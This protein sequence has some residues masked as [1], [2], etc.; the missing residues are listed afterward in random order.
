MTRRE[1]GEAALR[2]AAKRDPANAAT[3]YNLGRILLMHRHHGEAEAQLRAAVTL[4][5]DH[6]NAWHDLGHVLRE[7]GRPK[8]ALDAYHNATIHLPDSAQAHSDYGTMLFGF[9]RHQEAYDELRR[10]LT[11]DPSSASAHGN[12]GALLLRTGYAI[13]AE[14]EC[15]TA[16]AQSPAQYRWLTNL[17]V[18]LRMQCR[19]AEAAECARKALAQ[20]A[21]YA[22]AHGNLLFDLT[23][24]P[25]VSAAAIFAEFRNWD[26]CHARPLTP[27]K[28]R[29]AVDP[30]PGRKLR[31]GY[32]S[33]D[34]RQHAVALFAEPLLR[35]HDRAFLELYLYSGV[36]AEDD[37]TRRFHDLADAWRNTVTLNDGQL[38]EVIRNDRIDV[39][40]DLS[41]HS[42]CNRLLTFARRPAP[43]QVSYLLG[44]GY[45]TGLSEMDAFLADDALAPPGSE[46]FFSEQIIRLPRIPLVYAPPLDMPAVEPL[47][48]LTR[49]QVAFGYFGRTERLNDDVVIAWARILAAVPHARLVLNNLPFHEPA[50]RAQF[51]A[52][53][54]KQGISSDRLDFVYTEPQQR[55]WAAYGEIDIALDPFPHNA[56]TTTIEA[57]WQGVP[58]VSLAGQPS[59]GRF[60]AS[61]LHAVGLDDWVTS[62]TD[63]Y[64]ARAVAA[65]SDLPALA[66]LRERLRP[67]MERSPLRDAAS[68]AR[69]VEQAYR[70]LWDEWRLG[71]SRRLHQLYQTGD[72]AGAVKVAHRILDR[73]PHNG[74]AHHVL[75]LLAYQDKRLADA[76]R[77][78]QAAISCTPH[79]ADLHANRAAILRKLGCLAEAEAAARTA[80]KLEP[81][82]VGALNNL[83]NILRDAGRYD[84]GAEQFRA[85]VR[86]APDFADAWVNLAWLLSLAGRAQ[87]A[88]DAARHAIACAPDNADAY[89]NLGLALMRQGRL[90][91]AEAA[92]RQALALRPDFALPHSNILFCLNYRPDAT[93]EE[94]FAEYQEWDRRHALPLWPKDACHDLDR[95]PNRK[96]RVGYVS[97]DFRQH[98]VALFA[99]PLLA[100][101]DRS[102]VEVHCYSEVAAP[103][104]VTERFRAVADHWHNTVGLSDADLAE[105]I[106]ADHID[107]L[108]DMAGHT[109]GNRLLTFAR[110]PAPIQVTYLLGHGY[111]SGLSAM[112][113][114][115]ADAQLAPPDADHLFSEQVIRLSRIPLCYQPPVEMPDVGP[116]PARSSGQ[117]TFGYFGRTVRLNDDVITAWARI[118]KHVPNARLVLN[119][120][121]FGEPAGREQMAARFAAL[122]IRADRLTLTCTSP[123]PVTWAAYGSVDIA[124]DPFPHNAGTTTIEALWQGVPVVSLAGRPTVGRFG[125][126]IL[127]AVGLDDWVTRDVDAYVARA[128]AAAADVDALAHLRATLRQ[129]FAASPLCD[130]AGLAREFESAYRILWQAWCG[131][132]DTAHLRRLYEAGDTGKAGRLAEALLARNPDH[133]GALHILGLIQLRAGDA[134]SAA[135]LL[136]HAAD[137]HP[138]AAI[139]SDLGV[140][141]RAQQRFTEAEATC[142]EALHLDPASASGLGNLGNILL[143]LHRPHEAEAELARALDV[144]PNRPWLLH[145]LAL[146][147]LAQGRVDC[148]E[149]ALRQALAVDPTAADA[150]ETLANLLSQSGRPVESEAHHRAALTEPAQRHR[151]L[152]NLAVALQVQGKH[153]EAI[154]AC[155]QALTVR[156]DYATAHAN[157]LFALN[158]AADVSAHDVFAE[159]R[160]WDR[161]H[162]APV[163]PARSEFLLDRTA[164]RRLRI[165]YVSADF[166]NHAAAFF[167][168]PLLAAHDRSN[169][170]L[171]CYAEVAAADAV[172][173]RFHARADQWRNISGMSDAAVAELIRQDQ[174]DV[175]VDMTGHTAG[176]RLLV[177]A[178]KPAPVQ[179]AYLLGHGYSSGLSA[180]D[181]F[182]SD[183]VLTPPHS[184]PYFSERIVRLPRLP[185][186][187]A[188]P[189]EMPPVSQLP[190]LT[191]RWVAFGYFG[192]PDRLTEDVVATW[193]RILDAVPRSRL[194]LN[195]FSFREPAFRGFM[196]MRFAEHGI[197]RRRL[198]MLATAPQPRT[199]AAYGAIDIALDPFPHNAGTTTIEALWQGVPVISL[200]G[201]PSVGRFGA[202]ILH[203]VAMDDWVV[204]DMNDY[205]ARAAAA[206]CDPSRLALTRA[207]LR[208]RVA[209]SPL[210]DP[211]DLARQVEAVYREAWDAWRQSC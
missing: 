139:L 122:G 130:A 80:L 43:V 18:A 104:G 3:R 79:Q 201:R 164:G 110:K 108:V 118:L 52:R 163:A 115:L 71:D 119:S 6:G 56:G 147:L 152:S 23:Y 179:V 82:S 95:S 100:N 13:A 128:I 194:V 63:Q 7:L 150:H 90:A 202:M 46:A 178:R 44:H 72:A 135:T 112:D 210:C 145:S 182:L 15:R 137:N 205:V 47:P 4:R 97:P 174:V 191:N 73:N 141:L 125:A 5:P 209:A 168:E 61:I 70:M 48:A 102:T 181:V 121:P 186:A 55:T 157:L 127:H 166:R 53:F 159:Y 143:D 149:A 10:A 96:L 111:S 136:R 117:I 116:L 161:Q 88:E 184:E 172:T 19:Y 20:K 42:A 37:T 32:V 94:V 133:A 35:A 83:G 34:F 78:L 93:P 190:A 124:L 105:Q 195:S 208:S 189:E 187:Y 203:A 148:A 180:M 89:N 57:L 8:D 200:A 12:L 169:V 170:E 31:V 49:G 151:V 155:R 14:A 206:A 75:G 146:A 33:A 142:R 11:L 45:T 76:D 74:D 188:P 25:D 2:R 144:T 193:A 109:A 207:G 21:D 160:T 183:A 62:N 199:W 173:R 204:S 85:A 129:R 51:L 113:A 87:Q 28:P 114:F 131:D 30:N 98:A 198:Q 58:V 156:P 162:A 54:A 1:E 197:E 27:A 154:A 192:R 36:A 29:F 175:L 69:S 171:F 68:L 9:N 99:E 165:G 26:R 81:N 134:C 101:H 126:A 66:R 77:H 123:Q 16:I 91:D 211:A 153:Q 40:V 38:A 67:Q 41:G 65:S 39:L 196:A 132:D 138:D 167:A 120:A 24:R 50:F 176:S 59:F 92:L 64:V 60:G 86:L 140:A 22:I 103:D 158:Y 106:R 177:F 107:I 185:L 84:E 17:G